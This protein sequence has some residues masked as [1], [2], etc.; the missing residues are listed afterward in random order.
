MNFKAAMVT[1]KDQRTMNIFGDNIWKMY[2]NCAMY[3]LK[4]KMFS[5]FCVNF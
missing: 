4:D 2:L 1:S 3:V 5:V